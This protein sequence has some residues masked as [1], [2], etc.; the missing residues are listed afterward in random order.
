[1]A[2]R[3]CTYCGLESDDLNLFQR[4]V[5]SLYGRK[6]RCKEC[7]VKATNVWKENNSEYHKDY[8][9]RYGPDY[10]KINRSK[11]NAKEAKRRAMKKDQSPI[12]SSVEESEVSYLYWLAKDLH[13]ISG[14]VYHVDH[15]YPIAK[16]GFHH[17]SNLQILPADMN[18]AKGAKL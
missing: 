5:R 10:C 1:M 8:L 18:L 3:T 2:A 15:I 7:S 6:N 13:A 17:P 4:D 11:I 14:E 9:K 16:G 12:L